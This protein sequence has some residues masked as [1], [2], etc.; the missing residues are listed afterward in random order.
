[1]RI[2][3]EAILVHADRWL[4][5]PDPARAHR[6]AWLAAGRTFLKLETERL[7]IRHRLGAGGGEVTA[8]RSYAVDLLVRHAWQRAA[9]GAAPEA[10]DCALV[11]LGGY[12]RGD[13]APGSDVDLLFLYPGRPDP[14][15]ARQV[16]EA[17]KLLWDV[18]LSVGH[19]FRSLGECVSMAREDLHSR[20]A[21]TDARL[22]WGSSVLFARLLRGLEGVYRKDRETEAFIEATRLEPTTARLPTRPLSR[23]ACVSCGWG[24]VPKSRS[25]CGRESGNCTPR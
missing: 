11:A 5:V 12:G 10:E 3:L 15:T 24:W 20:T 1:M 7:R 22:L 4:D 23:S 19:S 25:G 16:E 2:D 14:A 13:L 8:A 17:L 6:D 18:G 21:M 9:P